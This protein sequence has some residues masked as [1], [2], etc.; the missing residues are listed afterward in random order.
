MQ[1]IQLLV[2]GQQ[3]LQQQLQQVQQQMQQMQQQMQ[4][5][6][7]Q[8]QTQHA[9]LVATMAAQGIVSVEQRQAIARGANAALLAGPL[10]IVPRDD[11]T[12]PQGWPPG[13]DRAMFREL[14]TAA[15]TA[16]LATFALAN[17]GTINAKRAR[18]AAHIGLIF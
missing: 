4:Q 15:V 17:I 13:L 7:Q 6:Q 9:A 11:G 1:A 2:N 18:I 8:M 14:S 3:Q 5:M 12:A 10:A 16:L